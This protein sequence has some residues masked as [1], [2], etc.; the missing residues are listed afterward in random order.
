VG[1]SEGTVHKE[2]LNVGEKILL[3]WII[4]KYDCAA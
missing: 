4:D 2:Y 3:K 1:T